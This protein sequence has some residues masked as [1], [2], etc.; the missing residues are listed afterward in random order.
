MLHMDDSLQQVI[1]T[2]IQ[3]ALR[4]KVLRLPVA[5]WTRTLPRDHVRI[6]QLYDRSKGCRNR[7]TATY[8]AICRPASNSSGMIRTPNPQSTC[9]LGDD[10]STRPTTPT[11][12]GHS[13]TPPL[14]SALSLLEP[15]A[16]GRWPRV[17]TSSRRLVG[18]RQWLGRR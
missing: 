8:A 7:R 2:G 16:K 11:R 13:S 5:I 6:D 15:A 4:M 12:Y 1:R 10:A 18:Y 17:S 3:N 9:T 14:T